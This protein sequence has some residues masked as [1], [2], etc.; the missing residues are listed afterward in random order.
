MT[1]LLLC[2]PALLFK[3]CRVEE[4]KL[5]IYC[6]SNVVKLEAIKVLE[7]TFDPCELFEIDCEEENT[8]TTLEPEEE[9]TDYPDY[10][11][12]EQSIS[13]VRCTGGLTMS[14]NGGC[15][16]TVTI[17]VDYEIDLCGI[18]GLC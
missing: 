4:K 1:L 3:I 18:F 12:Y 8:Q 15:V 14:P 9:I 11:N 6:T 7:E 5:F 10:P 17:E 13:S 16:E 2:W